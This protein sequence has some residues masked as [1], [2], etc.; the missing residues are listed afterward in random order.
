MGRRSKWIVGILC[1]LMYIPS[2]AQSV[3]GRWKTIDDR[4]GNPKAIIAILEPRC[5]YG[6]KVRDL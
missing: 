3:F 6:Q 1:L 2:D 5:G 4:T